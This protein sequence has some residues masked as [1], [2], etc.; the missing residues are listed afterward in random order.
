MKEHWNSWTVPPGKEAI[1]LDAFVRRCLPHLSVRE[2]QRAIAER[3]FWV[4]GRPG[5]K[6]ARLCAGDIVSYRGAPH[7]LAT[8]PPPDLGLPIGVLYE[9]DCVLALD[10][11]AGLPT[12][13]FS[14]R[15]RR[16]LA[17]FLIAA[18]PEL[19]AVGRSRWE[20]GLLHRLDRETSGLVL[21]AKDQ[22]SFEALRLQFRRGLVEK[23][24][25]ALVWGKVSGA[26]LLSYPLAH[27][28]SNR[29]KMIALKRGRGKKTGAR[30]WP[31]STRLAALA[32]SQGLTLLEV[33]IR[34]GVTHQIRAHLEAFGHPLVG[35]SLYGGG[36]PCPF[37][38]GR[39]FLHAYRIGFRHPRSG[40]KVVVRSPLS[41]ELMRV[42]ENLEITPPCP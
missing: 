10:K 17:N 11:P 26:R 42:L 35:D 21:A 36:R 28:P 31:A 29:K 16:S 23:K 33:D 7:L 22:D 41:G 19:A 3:A 15:E 20:P 30:I 40:K 24:Y 14:G 37:A 39:Q 13:G 8:T 4:N 25:W 9:D 2:A 34:T 27:D 32:S 1:R 38:L 18:R 12:H 5:K 6:G